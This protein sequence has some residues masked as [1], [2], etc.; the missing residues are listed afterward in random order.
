MTES[1][2]TYEATETDESAVYV[3]RAGTYTLTGATLTKTGDTSS[4]ADNNFYGINALVLAED[5]STIPL[6]DSTLYSNAD[7]ANGIFAYDEG[8]TI[9]VE[10]CTIETHGD[11]S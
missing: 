5:G 11:S 7:G 1:N 8:T 10:G 6:T 3:Y 9:Y 4:D 2:L